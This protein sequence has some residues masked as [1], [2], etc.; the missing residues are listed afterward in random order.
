MAFLD[1]GRDYL[2]TAYLKLAFCYSASKVLLKQVNTDPRVLINYALTLVCDSHV[3]LTYSKV[4]QPVEK[5]CLPYTC[6]L[7]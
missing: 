2:K 7:S 3:Q 6:T 5:H 4:D 1:N